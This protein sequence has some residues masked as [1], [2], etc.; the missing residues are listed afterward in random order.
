MRKSVCTVRPHIRRSSSGKTGWVKGH[1][2][3]SKKRW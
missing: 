2:R 3:V 1:I